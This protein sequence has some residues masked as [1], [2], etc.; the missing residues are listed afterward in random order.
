MREL[1]GRNIESCGDARLLLEAIQRQYPFHSKAIDYLAV[2]LAESQS[3]PLVYTQ[4]STVGALLEYVKDKRAFLDGD[5]EF[6]RG[7]SQDN[8]PV[9]LHRYLERINSGRLMEMDVGATVDKAFF[10]LVHPKRWGTRWVSLAHHNFTEYR[11]DMYGPGWAEPVYWIFG[12]DRPH[13]FEI[14]FEVATGYDD[15]AVLERFCTVIGSSS[16]ISTL[17]LGHDKFSFSI[18]SAE[19]RAGRYYKTHVPVCDKKWVNDDVLDGE[20]GKG[21]Q[22]F[23]VAG[24]GVRLGEITSPK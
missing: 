6:I 14:G 1:D 24:G 7:L 11:G 10:I 8:L 21:W 3:S 20:W 13:R 17:E 5:G 9:Y 19:R 15:P 12:G 22:V 16:M 23:G 4:L 2:Q 18:G